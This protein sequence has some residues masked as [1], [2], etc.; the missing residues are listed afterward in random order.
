MVHKLSLVLVFGAFAAGA[1]NVSELVGDPWESYCVPSSENSNY[2]VARASSLRFDRHEF[3]EIESTYGD[4]TCLHGAV[5]I[6]Q[7]VYRVADVE[8]SADGR[9]LPLTYVETR[10]KPETNDMASRLNTENAC[11]ISN[12][13]AGV[14][15]VC[16]LHLADLVAVYALEPF[17]EGTY[18][19]WAT[20]AAPEF[21]VGAPKYFGRLRD[22]E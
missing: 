22:S 13:H 3:F 8:V 19:R 17:A 15:R 21:K 10:V 2:G 4:T 16:A 12:W 5:L 11:G 6:R 14:T 18:L 20:G 1:E 7:N 9:R